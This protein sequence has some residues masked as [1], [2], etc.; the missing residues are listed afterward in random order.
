MKK[1]EI[2]KIKEG[3]NEDKKDILSLFSGALSESFEKYSSTSV[4]KAGKDLNENMAKHHENTKK[5]LQKMIGNISG[6]FISLRSEIN[7]LKNTK[8]ID[9]RPLWV[10]IAGFRKDIDDFSKQHKIDIQFLSKEFS[11][12]SKKIE[13]RMGSFEF[14]SN[15][16]LSLL[17][18]KH[19][20]LEEEVS[21]HKKQSDSSFDVVAKIIKKLEED[22]KKFG[23]SV[24]EFGSSFSILLNSIT[25]G[26]TFGINFIAGTG[27][28][29]TT[30]VNAQGFI[31]LT[32][33]STGGGTWYQ[34][35][36]VSGTKNG[37]NKSF[38]LAH[39]PATVVFLYLNGQIQV[40][41]TDYTRS[42]TA[43]SMTSAPLSTDSLTATYS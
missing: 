11:D 17:Q 43:I 28:T 41:G 37:S 42:G 32:I 12:T 8:P 39:S 19:K 34:D 24:Y 25:V 35:E 23:K 30:A 14:P 20:T 21:L 36:A 33:S 31:S 40:S 3:V 9:L 26:Q 6:G 27:I 4:E 38:T 29:I 7:G 16:D 10:E 22:I 1:E 15:E 18:D 2:K 5:E 13:E